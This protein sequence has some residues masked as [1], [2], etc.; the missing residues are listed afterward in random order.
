MTACWLLVVIDGVL[1]G[2]GSRLTPHAYPSTPSPYTR[3]LVVGI[4]CRLC[5]LVVV[6]VAV[7]LVQATGPREQTADED[8]RESV[9]GE[10]SG[11]ARQDDR[12]G[13]HRQGKGASLARF[14]SHL[15]YRSTVVPCLSLSLSRGV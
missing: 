9:A 10:G 14:R 13:A 8:P 2:F 15:F 4:C 5:F 3:L 6:V 11:L 1:L 12:L 7:G